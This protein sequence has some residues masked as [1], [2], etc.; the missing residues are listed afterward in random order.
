GRD[1]GEVDAA[2]G[3]EPSVEHPRG[4]IVVAEAIAREPSPSVTEWDLASGAWI[5]SAPLPLPAAF[6]D[7]RVVRAGGGYQVTASAGP[8]LDIVHLRLGR[9]LDARAVEHLGVGERP[10]DLCGRPVVREQPR[11]I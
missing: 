9:G 4:T 10:R 1:W 7:L 2:P 8:M 6:A 11:A 5:R 3:E